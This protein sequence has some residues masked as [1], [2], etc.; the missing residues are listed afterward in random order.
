M[1]ASFLY[2]VVL[3]LVLLLSSLLAVSGQS[4][5]PYAFC[6]SST[7]TLPTSPGLPWQ[8]TLSGSLLI[9]DR[10]TSLTYGAYASYITNTGFP[11]SQQLQGYPVLNATGTR[12]VQQGGNSLVTS[13]ITGI[14]AVNSYNSNDNI[15]G[16]SSP[17]FDNL[18]HGLSFL[19][20]SQAVFAYGQY[21]GGSGV[22]GSGLYTNINNYT[23]P[24][25]LGAGLGESDN[26]PNDG[27]ANV[28]T[29]T[30]T[31][32]KASTYTPT[33]S[34]GTVPTMPQP[35]SSDVAAYRQT[36]SYPFC[37]T[38][39]G[40]G[41]FATTNGIQWFINGA[42]SLTTTGYQGKTV[43]GQAAYLVTGISG[44]RT[45]IN[46]GIGVSGASTTLQSIGS[47]NAQQLI[48]GSSGQFDFL[49][50][51]EGSSDISNNVFYPTYPYFDA[52]GLNVQ[53]SGAV[54]NEDATNLTVS[55]FRLWVDPSSYSFN[56]WVS[57]PNYAPGYY[58][59]F[60]TYD[61]SAVFWSQAYLT[62]TQLST[63]AFNQQCQPTA[64]PT[65]NLQF[66]YYVDGSAQPTT[67]YFLYVYGT[68][69][70]TGPVPRNGR[71]AYT[72]QSMNGVRSYTNI[73]TGATTNDGIVFLEWIQ[74]DLNLGYINDNLLFTSPPYIT[75]SGIIYGT[76]Q[77][78]VM[79]NG[80]VPANVEVFY[81]YT[82]IA[83]FSSVS[84]NQS[85]GYT[86]WEYAVYN[87]VN[88][89]SSYL[90][91]FNF[92]YQL[93]NGP[94]SSALCGYQGSAQYVTPITTQTYS[95]C[96]LMQGSEQG[97]W[98]VSVSG[99]ITVY[100]API[101][102]NGLTA[103]AI[104]NITGTRTYQ[105]PG[106]AKSSVQITGVVG[107]NLGGWDY[108]FDNLL[109]AQA[110]YFD[111]DGLLFTFTGTAQTIMGPVAG[112]GVNTLNVFYDTGFY[113]EEYYSASDFSTGGD[114]VGSFNL[115]ADSGVSGATGGNVLSAQCGYTG[116]TFANQQATYG[117]CYA[118]SNTLTTSPYLPWTVY[119]QGTLS[120]YTN[121]YS[122]GILQQ[123]AEY[124]G[125]QA[126]A[127]T[128]NR[129]IW[130]QG[131]GPVSQQFTLTAA[132]LYN[133][134]D[135]IIQTSTVSPAL[136]SLHGL[137]FVS[138]SAVVGVTGT[139]TTVSGTTPGSLMYINLNGWVSP[140][141]AGAGITEADL[142]LNDGVTGTLTSVITINYG[143][144]SIPSCAYSAPAL[145]SGAASA[146]ASQVQW[147]F[148]YT[149]TGWDSLGTNWTIAASGTITTAGYV[150]TTVN[151][152]QA[153]AV[154]KVTGTRVLTLGALGG[155][156]YTQSIAN[157]GG[158]NN[159][160]YVAEGIATAQFSTFF[161][162][163]N[164]LYTQWPYFDSY[165]LS[166]QLASDVYL[167]NGGGLDTGNNALKIFI[168]PA[169]Y[170][171]A[172][173]ALDWPQNT[174]YVGEAGAL[175]ISRLSSVSNTADFYQQCRYD[176]GQLNT[177]QWCYY[178][179]RTGQQNANTGYYVQAYGTLTARG[180]VTRQGKTAY[181]VQSMSGVRTFTD[182]ASGVS[183]SVVILDL[184][185]VG[186]DDIYGGGSGL[187]Y[188]TLN[189]N[190]IFASSPYLTT[191]GFIY[192]TF[193]TPNP[194]VFGV[195]QP[196]T[197]DIQVNVNQTWRNTNWQALQEN[198]VGTED[199]TTR[200][201][202]GLLGLPALG[203][204]HDPGRRVLLLPVLRPEHALPVP[205]S[206]H[207]Q[208]LLCGDGDRAVGS[209]VLCVLVWP[210]A[211][212]PAG[213]DVHSTVL[214]HRIPCSGY[215]WVPPVPGQHRQQF[216]RN[217]HGAGVE[218][219]RGRWVELRSVDVQ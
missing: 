132:N 191:E 88:T 31:L 168:D 108:E 116:A 19:L 3:S 76:S 130:A 215:Q 13:T 40:G 196:A 34:C 201:R 125:F 58:Y 95:F 162:A 46:N 199:T 152:L 17:Y 9:D 173:W 33:V 45:Y 7:Q 121:S 112:D 11:A 25:A 67:P 83:L 14:A 85:S 206:D 167:P 103:Y 64:G 213:G 102:S 216:V 150:G 16:L 176:Y 93:A 44:T 53:A 38:F 184:Q 202:L 63:A 143:G 118:V 171:M 212:V 211:G 172:E 208:L 49:Y 78:P 177:Y 65:V 155:Q 178:L 197:Y 4:G 57:D 1:A 81:G 61:A 122:T 181:T 214:G 48:A 165:G 66:C 144:S 195:G 124:P 80:I 94:P 89:A 159:F 59:W 115:I 182:I 193:P 18:A 56:E 149:F 28:I 183:S 47:P 97:G 166:L 5:T 163:N 37:Y 106:G 99:T 35:S 186:N 79:P 101:T 75:P 39:T 123:S 207:V 142:P 146:Y 111:S 91:P 192:T 151:G 32:T 2:P 72:L 12:T 55:T 110:P 69:T 6:F 77:G 210:A 154:L 119:G 133:G 200:P 158:F 43:S 161:T 109:Y 84:G 62:Q 204:Q 141:P 22:Q 60:F 218:L 185:Y 164:V 23:Y 194:P 148:C 86:L 169:T 50:Q 175:Q 98:Q 131:N 90:A 42:G 170:D 70:A 187:T 114:S 156:T 117:F 160:Q 129:T 205:G 68:A 188:W 96:Y 87:S 120:V 136:V 219:V 82:D 8:V 41:N 52:F 113:Q 174:Y 104:Q 198:A 217:H 20:S 51:A 147:A 21:S 107:N 27:N 139:T 10:P 137:S 73:T 179:D 126:Y 54:G 71:M 135:N 105:A 100:T 36:A 180:P 145:P 128:L 209:V 30:F 15:I 140:A 29:S 127:G 153:Q 74:S 138:T 189:D 92:G 157:V 190:V 134:N 203:V 24:L 26:P